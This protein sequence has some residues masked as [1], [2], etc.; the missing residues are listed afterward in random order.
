MKHG[1]EEHFTIEG[2]ILPCWY[3]NLKTSYL[4]CAIEN[5]KTQNLII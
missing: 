3:L 4:Q 1:M 5:Y 2:I